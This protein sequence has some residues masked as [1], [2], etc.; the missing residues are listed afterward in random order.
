MS[1]TNT[2]GLFTHYLRNNN[3]PTIIHLCFHSGVPSS[4]ISQGNLDEDSHSSDHV[5]TFTT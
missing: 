5:L 4:M 2:P 1:L 3:S